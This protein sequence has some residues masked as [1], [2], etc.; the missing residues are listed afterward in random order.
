VVDK[1]MLLT[2]GR[3]ALFGQRE[4]VLQQLNAPRKQPGIEGQKGG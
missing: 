1:I 4:Q 2:D 3:V